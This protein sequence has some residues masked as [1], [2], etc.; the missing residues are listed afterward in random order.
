LTA[1]PSCTRATFSLR[2][3]QRA[4]SVLGRFQPALV[5]PVLLV[6]IAVI[7]DDYSVLTSFTQASIARAK[8]VYS[9]L[10]QKVRDLDLSALEGLLE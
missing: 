4:G 1:F 8:E 3:R 10:L 9:A 7:L 2:R 6:I 5:V